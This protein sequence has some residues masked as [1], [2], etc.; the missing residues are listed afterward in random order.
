[1]ALGE[2]C[3]VRARRVVAPEEVLMPKGE[4]KKATTNKPKLSVKE[5][6]K[7]KAQKKEK[8]GKS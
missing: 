1:V 4:Q 5:K 3:S 7:K 6:A 8:A 2:N